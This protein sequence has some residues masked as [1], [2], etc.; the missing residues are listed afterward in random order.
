MQ[1]TKLEPPADLPVAVTRF[2]GVGTI[3]DTREAAANL[4]A[5]REVPSRSSIP[6]TDNNPNEQWQLALSRACRDHRPDV[7][8]TLT[9]TAFHRSSSRW[10]GISDLI[11][12]PEGSSFIF[13]TV[14]QRRLD[15][16][17]RDTRPVANLMNRRRQMLD[18]PLERLV[19]RFAHDDV[20]VTMSIALDHTIVPARRHDGY[21]A[22]RSPNGAADPILP[23]ACQPAKHEMRHVPSAAIGAPLLVGHPDHLRLRPN[24]WFPK[25]LRL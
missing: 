1:I 3:D 15:G 4:T 7:S 14:A 12:E 9:T 23:P 8:A 20:D 19:V 11:A 10:L 24:G 16:D 18:A 6:V 22:A 13:S 2:W 17:A 5:G 25:L 21:I